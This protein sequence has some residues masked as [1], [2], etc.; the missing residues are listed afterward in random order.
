MTFPN[1]TTKELGNTSFLFLFFYPLSE[2]PGEKSLS[3]I[4]YTFVCVPV[5]VH[6]QNADL[7]LT[8]P[9][10]FSRHFGLASLLRPNPIRFGREGDTVTQES[11]ALFAL[12]LTW[13]VVRDLPAPVHFLLL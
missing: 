4:D 12:T 2:D 13:V 3:S 1:A 7:V 10:R 6:L 8:S 5:F 11:T 9:L